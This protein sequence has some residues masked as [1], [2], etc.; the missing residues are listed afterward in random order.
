MGT[1]FTLLARLGDA[2]MAMIIGAMGAGA[3][4]AVIAAVVAPMVQ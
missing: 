2:A 4:M 1:K 3:T